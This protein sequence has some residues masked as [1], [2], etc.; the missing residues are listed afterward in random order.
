MENEVKPTETVKEEKPVEKVVEQPAMT[1]EELRAENARLAQ[2]ALN[3]EEEAKRHFAKL[4]AF[5]KKEQ[6][7]K[8]AELSDLQ[9]EQK[10]AADLERENKELKTNQ[11]KLSIAAKIGIP[12]SLALRLQGETPDDIEKDAKAIL[13]TLPKKPAATGNP[14]NPGGGSQAVE[15]DAERR[16]RLGI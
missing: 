7:K 6:D 9:K 16:K 2:H 5:E 12:E 14:T 1:L 8:D 15:T 4:Q 11:L 10:R 3:K 13:E